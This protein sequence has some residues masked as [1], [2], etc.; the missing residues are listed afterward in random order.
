MI[1]K[2]VAMRRTGGSF[3]KLVSYLTSGRGKTERVGLVR[4]TN[5][6]SVD[7]E[8]A[9]LEVENA[10]A[11]NHRSRQATCHLILAFPAGENPAAEVLEAIERRACDALGFT[12]HHRV[13]VV[14]HDTDHVHVHIAINRVHPTTHRV[15]WPSYSK[16]LLDRVCVE[17]EREYGLQPVPHRTRGREE[18]LQAK[19][20]VL[21]AV[22]R[23]CADALRSARTWADLHAAAEPYSLRVQLRGNGI[24]LVSADGVSVKASSVSRD[25][26]K[27]AL[28]KRLGPFEARSAALAEVIQSAPI[29]DPRPPDMERISGFESLVGWIQR[30]CA[31][32]LRSASSWAEVHS[33]ATRHGLTVRLRGNGL[34]FVASEGI[35]VKA[36]SVSRDLSKASLETRLGPFEA[37]RTGATRQP[38]TQYRKRPAAHEGGSRLYERYL[39]E[40]EAAV[41]QRGRAAAHIRQRRGREEE[42]Q[43]RISR[44]RWAAVRFVAK[45]RVAWRLWSAYARQ[46][47]RRDWERARQRHRDAARAAATQHPRTGWLEWLRQKAAS[48]DAEA[49]STLRKRSERERPAAS[50]MWIEASPKEL[51]KLT[52]DSVTAK[53]TMIYRVPGGSIRDDGKRLHL[54]PT[55]GSA[56][57]AAVLLRMAYARFGARIEVAGDQAFRDRLVRAAVSAAVP[58]T[59]ADAQLER[60]RI[61]LERKE[62]SDGHRGIPESEQ[63][64]RSARAHD[65]ANSGRGGAAADGLRKPNARRSRK[66]PPPQ[67]GTGLRDVSALDVVRF[68]HAPEVLLPRDARRDVEQ[69]GTGADPVVRRDPDQRRIDE[70]GGRGKRRRR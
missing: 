60:R 19:Q 67:S 24:V 62:H 61:E 58:I 3:R 50:A 33:I 35:A 8:S 15:H 49:L 63:R 14:H 7:V 70:L 30:G 48:G 41:E 23:E 16:L 25:L 52:R 65:R 11:R 66:E 6:V 5:C 18:V 69:R 44:R 4:L 21:A 1:A 57:S 10:Q 17:V 28:E 42:R 12:Q 47:D 31:E 36:S 37:M 56:E 32:G 55:D 13:T 64:A 45:G 40:C 20:Q 26:S 34:V 53:G 46:A 38:E 22:T 59:F 39:R 29:P 54:V 27:A 68:G 51:V 9:V 2:E 43:R